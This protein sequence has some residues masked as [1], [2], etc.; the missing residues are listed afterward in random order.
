MFRFFRKPSKSRVDFVIVGLGNPGLKYEGTRHNIGFDLLRRFSEQQGFQKFKALGNAM[1]CEKAM[2]MGVVLLVLPQT[3]M[4]ASGEVFGNLSDK[5]D[6]QTK[7]LLVVSDD[8]DLKLGELRFREKG[9]SGGHNGLKSIEAAL[10]TNEYQRLKFGIGRKGE[11][12]LDFV[13]GHWGEE[14]KSIVTERVDIAVGS[15]LFWIQNKDKRELINSSFNR[16]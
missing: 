9:S 6:F 15:L 16:N 1:V 11:S 2:P 4:N 8:M 10:G 12:V 13:L 7:D 14:E 5:Y 3:F